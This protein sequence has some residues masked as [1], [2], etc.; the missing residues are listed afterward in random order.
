MT[1]PDSAHA[2]IDSVI[3]DCG[4]VKSDR[5]QSASVSRVCCRFLM[6]RKMKSHLVD[7]LKTDDDLRKAISASSTHINTALFSCSVGLYA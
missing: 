2:L 4:E 1:D 3:S 6:H 7:T 5:A